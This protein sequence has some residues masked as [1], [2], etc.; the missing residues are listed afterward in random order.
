[1]TRPKA[2]S[3]GNGG[4]EGEV[5]ATSTAQLTRPKHG[6][7]QAGGS[8]SVSAPGS[9]TVAPCNT[10]ASSSAQST[11]SEVPSTMA[12]APMRGEGGEFVKSPTEAAAALAVA[13]VDGTSTS[14]LTTNVKDGHLEGQA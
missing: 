13:A 8:G 6:T 14:K 4:G 3:F 10:P 12:S 7:L 9:S 2:E 11:A 1:M 5:P